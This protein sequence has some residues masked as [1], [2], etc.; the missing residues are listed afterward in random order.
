[1]LIPQELA[2][3]FALVFDPVAQFFV[4]PAFYVRSSYMRILEINNILELIIPYFAVMVSFLL[5]CLSF[6]IFWHL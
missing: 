4:F 3:N 2:V 5:Q 1:M 6:D